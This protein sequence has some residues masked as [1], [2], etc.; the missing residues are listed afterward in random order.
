MVYLILAVLCGASLAVC[1]KMF[2]KLGIDTFQGVFVNYLTAI[3]VS[4]V[5][6]GNGAE[7]L[8]T[9]IMA[10]IRAPWSWLAIVE[11]LFFMGGILVLAASTQRSGVAVTNVSARASMAFAVVACYFAFH[12]Q[13]PD[14]FAIALILVG[15]YLIFG[16][17]GR[18]FK[19][20]GAS[21]K[22]LESS[23]KGEKADVWSS[24]LPVAVFLTYGIC[25]FLL[26]YLKA[27][28]G[29]DGNQ[30][31]I[32]LFI[33]STAAV[34]CVI[35]YLVRGH[36]SEH[37]FSWKAIPGG[38]VLGLFNSSCTALM[39]KALGVMDAVVFYPL[40]NVGV[41]FL[42]LLIGVMFFKEKLRPVQICGIVL[43]TAA[44]VLLL[45]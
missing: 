18:F 10:A 30:G 12:E 38:I 17:V 5:L 21:G 4:L 24:L 34:F 6:S 35:A 1:F 37:P 2:R 9:S 41:V 14:W 7:S 44:I 20:A 43:A 16:N 23:G 29:T 19:G 25:D 45:V 36:F 11:G 27:Q 39:L 15:M 8:G 32:M 22:G 26:K 3:A 28:I 31:N 33:F 13:A 40:Y 42:S